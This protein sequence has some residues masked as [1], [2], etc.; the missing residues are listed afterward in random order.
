M[1]CTTRSE[2]YPELKEAYLNKSKIIEKRMIDFRK[3]NLPATFESGKKAVLKFIEKLDG[4]LSSHKW[5]AG[6]TYS[7][8]DVV[9]TCLLARL[10]FSH[11]SALYKAMPNLIR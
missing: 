6:D 8:A 9:S 10:E 5:A 11:E 2:Q 3:E 4:Q 7:L 1:L